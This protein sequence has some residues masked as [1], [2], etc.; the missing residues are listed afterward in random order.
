VDEMTLAERAIEEPKRT[1]G[2]DS[3]NVRSNYYFCPTLCRNC[4]YFLKQ[5]STYPYHCKAG[6][7]T[8]ASHKSKK[9]GY[10]QYD[11]CRQYKE[12]EQQQHNLEI[13]SRNEEKTSEIK[14]TSYD[15]DDDDINTSE[16][17]RIEREEKESKREI[18]KSERLEQ[19]E[20]DREEKKR[21]EK[22]D[23]THCFVCGKEDKEEHLIFKYNKYFHE[24]CF[25]NFKETSNGKKWV[26]EKEIYF[27]NLKKMS[28]F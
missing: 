24:D 15:D 21:Q 4:K 12:K 28:E 11:D 22:Y 27:A 16:K 18:Q 14:K 1:A 8:A 6:S 9:E 19:F 17:R 20:R 5:E 10:K 23:E 2:D 13:S 3:W 25:S 7:T 26:E